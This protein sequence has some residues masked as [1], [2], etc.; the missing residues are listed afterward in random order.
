MADSLGLT[1]S[2]D[3]NNFLGLHRP[4]F[5]L[6]SLATPPRS[7]GGLGLGLGLALRQSEGCG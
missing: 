1:D 7:G 4:P 5:G 6:V 3:S 2:C